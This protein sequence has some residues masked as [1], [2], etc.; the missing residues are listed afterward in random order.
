MTLADLLLEADQR[1]CADLAYRIVAHFAEE[2]VVPKPLTRL[3]Q[4]EKCVEALWRNVDASPFAQ[5]RKARYST[6]AAAGY[7]CATQETP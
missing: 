3:E 5:A 1:G 7:G 6:D 4:A 2:P